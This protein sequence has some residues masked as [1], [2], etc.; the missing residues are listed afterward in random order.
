MSLEVLLANVDGAQLSFV[1]CS[2]EFAGSKAEIL[3]MAHMV[4]SK[5]N[6]T[7]EGVA[8]MKPFGC[9]ITMCFFWQDEPHLVHQRLPIAVANQEKSGEV[10]VSV[11][12]RSVP[13]VENS[14]GH[15]MGNFDSLPDSLTDIENSPNVIQV[16]EW[17]SF[18]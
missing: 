12:F 17:S 1:V 2:R 5:V 11:V 15:R 10:Q 16:R 13:S 8:A 7:L 18:H 3:G 14:V 4:L 6:A 9:E